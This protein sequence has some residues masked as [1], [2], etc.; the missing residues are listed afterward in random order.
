MIIYKDILGKLKEAGWNT[1]RLRK[2]KKLSESV[3]QRLR[4]GRP[5]T[6][7][8][9]NILCTLCNCRVEDLIEFQKED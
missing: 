5:I 8:T 3:L 6:T 4:D 9:I 1:N 7:E 2:E